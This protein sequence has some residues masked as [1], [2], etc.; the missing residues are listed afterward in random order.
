[1]QPKETALIGT[2]RRVGG[3]CAMQAFAAVAPIEPLQLLARVQPAQ[4]PRS[5]E[6]VEAL[7]LIWGDE[8]RFNTAIRLL[9]P[10]AD[11]KTP[12]Q[13]QDR[14]PIFLSQP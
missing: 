12:L 11:A 3:L 14:C 9:W 4:P 6:T 1:M 2:V 13:W 7:Q 10:L 8:P 5:V